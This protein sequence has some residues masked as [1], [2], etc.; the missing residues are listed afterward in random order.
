VSRVARTSS[1]I[2][3]MDLIVRSSR[4]RGKTPGF[5]GHAI[6]DRLQNSYGIRA[7]EDYLMKPLKAMITAC[8]VFFALLLAA[9]IYSRGRGSMKMEHPGKGPR[10]Y[11][12]L[13]QDE[14]ML[15]ADMR[16]LRR[17]LRRS[18]S[19]IRIARE[20]DEIRQDWLDIVA[21]RG[22]KTTNVSPGLVNFGRFLTRRNSKKT[23]V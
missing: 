5:I 21:Q 14:I 12:N 20:R 23:D 1:L 16:K 4:T 6:N 13:A 22:L 10:S 18:A 17:D 7:Q 2:D 9:S 8:V 15:A 11:S 19:Q 3:G